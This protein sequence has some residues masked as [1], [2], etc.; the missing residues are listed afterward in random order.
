M[1]FLQ[2]LKK[3]RVL[4]NP[5]L[6]LLVPVTAVAITVTGII[7]KQDFIR[8]LPLYFS[9]IIM[10]LN[11]RANRYALLLGSLNSVLYTFTY[12]YLGLYATAVH[13]FFFS[14]PMQLLSFVR[15]KKNSYKKS[16]EFRKLTSK[17]RLLLAA[18]FIVTFCAVYF[19][20]DS[21]GSSYKFLDT[22]SS[23]ISII[24]TFL[25]MFAFI[26]YTWLWIPSAVL[27]L[28]LTA[29]T[30]TAHPEQITYLIYS[31]YSLICVVCSYTSVRKLYKEQEAQKRI[32]Y[33][34]E[35]LC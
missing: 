5:I 2:N 22:L 34:G 23:L 6:F 14:F 27:S 8:I 31:V 24:V 33:Q 17:Q 4:K 1:Q 9:L 26:E 11:S 32:S 25:T 28:I 21:A 7:W 19:I 13:A 29:M 30:M 12:L 15:W 35:K 16:T 3:S 18:S 10:F 20:L